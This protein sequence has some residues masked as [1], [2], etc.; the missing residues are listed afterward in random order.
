M[1]HPKGSNT[2][3]SGIAYVGIKADLST[4]VDQQGRHTY[5][6]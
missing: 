4:P 6:H 5:A 1:S 3:P 2:P